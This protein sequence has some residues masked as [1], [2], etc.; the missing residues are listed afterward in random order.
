MSKYPHYAL[1]KHLKFY[2]ILVKKIR[3]FVGDE[4]VKKVIKTS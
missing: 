4:T 3:L 2:Y 1:L